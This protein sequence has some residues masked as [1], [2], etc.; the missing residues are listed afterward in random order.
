MDILLF[1]K[2]LLL[3]IIEG[4]TE[5]LPISSTGHL[6]VFGDLLNF[7]STGKV[8]EV[9]IQLGAVLAV[10]FEYRQR[11]LSVF[12]GLG[13]KPDI[14]RFVLN[15]IIAFIPA[16]VVGLLFSSAIKMHFFNPI[17]VASALVIGGVVILF[18]EKYQSNHTPRVND[19]DDMCWKDALCVGLAQI[20]A[21]IPGTSRSG[22]T[23]MGGM[24]FGLSRKVATEF[25][26]FLA[27]PIMFAATFYDIYKH[28]E[29]FDSTMVG[30]IITGFVAAFI[31]GLLAIRALL[32][33]VAAKNYV[34]FAWYR[35]VFGGFILLSWYF[36][37]INWSN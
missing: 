3:G 22:S 37:W 15:I 29:L 23:I 12:L 26:F 9:A 4:V 33:F 21:L 28:H 27:V 17:T 11:F 19:V 36:G 32:K 1:F 2:A 13:R 24:A 7:H 14:N 16:A 6:I 34:P 25:S 31:S 30:T 20:F 5:F 10:V 8:F 18:I 35:I